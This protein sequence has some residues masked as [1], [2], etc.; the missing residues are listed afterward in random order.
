VLNEVREF[1]RGASQ[2]DDMTLLVIRYNQ[3]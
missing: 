3:S 2:T 1:S